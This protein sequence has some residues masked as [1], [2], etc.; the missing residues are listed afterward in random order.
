MHTGTA[1]EVLITQST[2]Q[3]ALWQSDFG[4]AYTQRNKIDPAARTPAFSKIIA[5]L[6]IQSAL[7]VGCNR[8]HNLRAL[9][10]AGIPKLSAVE[11]NTSARKIAQALVPSANIAEGAAQH[12]P[13]DTNSHDLVFTVGVLI[14]IA[15][16]D[17]PAAMQEMARVSGRYLLSIEWFADQ[18]TVVPYRGHQQALWKTDFDRA[19]RDTCPQLTLIGRG[20]VNEAGVW[21]NATWCLYEQTVG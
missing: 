20:T 17:L 2:P 7:E 8:G 9:E 13:F 1:N 6:S 4:D 12:L 19:W 16:A 5:D 18:P 21:E 11:P 14:H 10:L 15:P 3:I